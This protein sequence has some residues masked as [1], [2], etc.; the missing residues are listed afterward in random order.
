MIRLVAATF[1]LILCIPQL[2][3]CQERAPNGQI[4]NELR[5][6]VDLGGVTVQL[7][8]FSRVFNLRGPSADPAK[9]STGLSRTELAQL[10][11]D[12][13]DDIASAFRERGVPLLQAGHESPD[14]PRLEVRVHWMKP[15]GIWLIDVT[16]RL[17]ERA[18]LIKDPSKPVWAETWGRMWGGYPTSPESLANDIRHGALGG[19]NEFLRLYVR[20]HARP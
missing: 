15:T 19:V 12:I 5:P 4:Y 18:R 16:T 2:A 1:W 11:R 10:E 13:H 9:D 14:T 6:F 3:F 17:M 20:A 8:C 7:C